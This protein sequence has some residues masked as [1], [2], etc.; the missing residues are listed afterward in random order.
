MR[1][2]DGAGAGR[3]QGFGQVPGDTFGPWK[4]DRLKPRREAQH[5]RA[6]ATGHNHSMRILFL[7]GWQSVPGGVKPTYLSQHGHRVINPKLPDDDFEAAVRIA[8]AEYDRHRPD[9]VVGSSRAGT[10]P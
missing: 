6:A 8:Q 9:V 4:G 2:D 1:G 7:H 3:P 10:W 5:S